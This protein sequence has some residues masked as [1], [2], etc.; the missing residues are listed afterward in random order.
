MSLRKGADVGARRNSRQITL[1]RFDWEWDATDKDANFKQEVAAYTR[2]DPMPT[3]ETMSR[4]LNIPVGAVVQ[5][6]LVRWAASGSTALLE[7]GPRV[8]RQMADVV[9]KANAADTDQGRLEAYRK[10]SQIIS[11]LNVPLTDP[12]WRP[13]RSEV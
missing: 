3:V 2:V 10:L 13:G 4:N 1:Q 5:F 12:E 8:V 11:W 7:I 9:D 6:V